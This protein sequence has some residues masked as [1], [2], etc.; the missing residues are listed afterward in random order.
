MRQNLKIN[1]IMKRL[2]RGY[3]RVIGLWMTRHSVEVD[4]GLH[5]SVCRVDYRVIIEMGSALRRGG[6]D[7]YGGEFSSILM[8]APLLY[9]KTHPF[10]IYTRISQ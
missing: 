10:I 2:C 8:L 3:M 1:D 4:F 6:P 9:D 7:R 5:G